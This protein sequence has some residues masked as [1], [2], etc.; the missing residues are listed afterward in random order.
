[1]LSYLHFLPSSQVAP[2]ALLLGSYDPS[3]VALSVAMAVLAAIAALQMTGLTQQGAGRM[4]RAFAIT[5]AT[6]MLGAGIWSMHFIG[7][8]AFQLCT[9]VG[10]QRNATLLSMVPGLAAAFVAVLVIT[11]PAPTRAQRTLSGVLIGAGIAAMHYS[12]MAAMVIGPQLHYD[13]AWFLLSLAAGVGLSVLALQIHGGLKRLR[14]LSTMRASIAGGVVLGLAITCTHYIGM[15]AALFV[16]QPDPAFANARPPVA[17]AL[18]VAL[19]SLMVI[20]LVGGIWG[21]LHYRTLARR[22]QVNENRLQLVIDGTAEGIAV[23]DARGRVYRFN[24]SAERVTGYSAAQMMGRRLD[25]MLSQRDEVLDAY[26]AGLPLPDGTAPIAGIVRELTVAQ[27]D[28]KRVEIRLSVGRVNV[29]DEQIFVAFVSDI[30]EQKQIERALRERE[31]QYGALIRNIPGTFF[32]IEL[33][34]ARTALF[35]SEQIQSIVGWPAADFLSGR[36]L[37]RDIVHPDDLP[38]LEARTDAIAASADTRDFSFECRLLHANGSHRWISANCEI[39][40]PTD[41]GFARIDGVMIDITEAKLRASEFEGTVR[42]IGHALAVIEFDVAGRVIDANQN[43]LDLTGYTL[44][45]IRGM[46]HAVFCDPA[47]VASPAY[48]DFWNTLRRGEHHV[49]EY[50]RFG[51][52]R[53]P[54]WLHASYNPVMGADGRLLK[55]VKFASDV[56]NRHAVQEALREAKEKAEQAAAA[57]TA[58][59]AN[60]SH[61][62]R[63]PMNAVIGF[64]ELLMDTP[65]TPVQR[66]HLGTVRQSAAAL[67]DLL[68]SVL[69]TAKLEKGAMELEAADFSLRELAGHVVDSLRIGKQAR[70]IALELDYQDG[71]GEHFRGDPMRLR[72]VLVNLVSNAV[73][74]TEAGSVRL[75]V[76]QDP[77]VAVVPTGAVALHLAVH[78]TG[79]GIPA[80][81]LHAIFQPFTQAD[82]SMSRRFGG[83]GLGITIAQQLVELMAGEISVESRVGVGSVFH[84]RLVLPT[85]EAPAAE[86]ARLAVLVVDDMLRDAEPP[87]PPTDTSAAESL[88]PASVAAEH[89]L[90]ALLRGELDNDALAAVDTALRRH[91]DAALADLIADTIGQFDFERAATLLRPLVHVPERI[92][93]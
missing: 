25:T 40:K 71:L 65:I 22:L 28:G 33:N 18:G 90:A 51:R 26:L 82:A 1:M 7:M 6:F 42:A 58:F 41:I 89:A 38:A 93:A 56:T 46:R 35:V 14:W 50:E 54:V 72:Q 24:L 49:G 75:V 43:F 11:R 31:A 60:M 47:Y 73:K 5:A 78:D 52:D 9:Q 66:Q 10:Y 17:L 84:V 79:I 88:P 67:L 53:R 34:P 20:G 3:F 83:T 59:L 68:N 80:D 87:Q 86:D 77:A 64:T 15:H 62:I 23:L 32:R 61:E 39:E 48:V 21:L 70:R 8:L 13:P 74:F 29:P 63:T 57:R 2:T 12:G 55:I 16:G 85:A 19:V 69:D 44:D 76:R 30:G 37:L 91:G 36:R 4:S 27:P 81:R 92:P 45:Q